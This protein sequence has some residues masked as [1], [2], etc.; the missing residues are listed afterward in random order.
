MSARKSGRGGTRWEVEKD[1]RPRRPQSLRFGK[2]AQG[3]ERRVP[4]MKQEGCW[5]GRPRRG[6]AARSPL[7]CPLPQ[8]ARGLRDTGA[9]HPRATTG[10]RGDWRPALRLTGQC[11]ANV[12]SARMNSRPAVRPEFSAW[13]PLQ[14]LSRLTF[15]CR[16]CTQILPQIFTEHK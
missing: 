14:H 3:A 9:G 6:R 12:L 16:V 2:G 11:S 7:L 1:Q 5:G 8:R 13:T 10:I 15:I 4:L